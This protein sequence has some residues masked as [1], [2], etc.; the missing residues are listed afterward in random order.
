L[1]RT[2][3]DSVNRRLT[4]PQ[5][6]LATDGVLRLLLNICGGLQVNPEVIRR[7]VEKALPFMATENIMMQAVARGG[8]RQVLHE[9]LRQHSHATAAQIKQG[10][11][12]NDLLDRLQK[13][14]AFARLDWDALRAP[15]AYVGRAPQQV[16]DWIREQVEPIRVRYSH[17]L[18]QSASVDV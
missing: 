7:N 14:P 2:L 5:A 11:D 17:L 6:F 4:L 10:A 13:D 1:E 9:K 18:G 8:D 12:K 15:E 3:D 16:E